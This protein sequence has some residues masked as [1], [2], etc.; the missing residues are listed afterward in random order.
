MVPLLC[1]IVHQ[2]SQTC[3]AGLGSV[4]HVIVSQGVLN[5]AKGNR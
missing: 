4:W 3:S 5:T 2:V 1:P